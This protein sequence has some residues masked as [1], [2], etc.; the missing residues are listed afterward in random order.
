MYATRTT[1]ATTTAVIAAKVESSRKRRVRKVRVV[2]VNGTRRHTIPYVLLRR[3]IRCN[4]E[5]T[6][7]QTKGDELEKYSLAVN[8][9]VK[10]GR[11]TRGFDYYSPFFNGL[12][13]SL[14]TNALCTHS[15]PGM[16]RSGFVMVVAVD[17]TEGVG[18][19]SPNERGAQRQPLRRDVYATSSLTPPE[20]QKSKVMGSKSK[21][22]E[23]VS[24]SHLKTRTRVDYKYF[25]SYRT[26]WLVPHVV[27][28]QIM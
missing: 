22:F 13:R 26:R 5:D 4:W 7:R 28:P 2:G 18:P 24:Q 14:C 16:C 3:E 19:A 25:L 12:P 11:N 10:D 20:C 21:H 6:E 23:P 1:F 8:G 27:Y 9:P 15:S 17:N